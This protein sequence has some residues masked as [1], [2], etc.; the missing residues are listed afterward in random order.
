LAEGRTN[1]EV[2]SAL[3]LGVSTIDTHRENLMQKLNLHNTAE[4][5]VY[6]IK[7]KVLRVE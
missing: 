5:V 6:A 3:G 4:L 7:K 1:K 2:A